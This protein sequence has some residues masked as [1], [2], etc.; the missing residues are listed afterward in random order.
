MRIRQANKS[1]FFDLSEFEIEPADAA[2]EITVARKTRI[3]KNVA[4]NR[5]IV[6]AELCQSV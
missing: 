3:D 1:R 2:G 6:Y 5:R 4:T